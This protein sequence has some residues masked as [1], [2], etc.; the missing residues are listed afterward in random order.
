MW[1]NHISNANECL[2]WGKKGTKTNS[3]HL[4]NYMRFL[5]NGIQNILGGDAEL[6]FALHEHI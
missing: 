3:N 1:L 5:S 2:L 4:L 6:K